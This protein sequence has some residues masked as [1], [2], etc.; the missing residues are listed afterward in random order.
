MV[1]VYSTISPVFAHLSELLLLFSM[2]MVPVDSCLDHEE[3]VRSE[4]KGDESERPFSM[5]QPQETREDSLE[6]FRAMRLGL[7]DCSHQVNAAEHQDHSTCCETPA[8]RAP[9]CRRQQHA[10]FVM[11]QTLAEVCSARIPS[12]VYG[13]TQEDDC[14][15]PACNGSQGFRQQPIRPVWLIAC[16][17]SGS[18]RKSA[19]KD[20]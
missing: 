1:V 6:S 9:G 7:E 4:S 5:R 17:L 3:P 15:Q 10:H 8:S 18:G 16:V 11:F 12:I 19:S 2:W 14:N 20:R 13:Y